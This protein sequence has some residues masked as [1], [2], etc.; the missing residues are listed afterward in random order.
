LV[1]AP[2]YNEGQG[3]STQV[4]VGVQE[5]L[6]HESWIACDALVSLDK[7]LLTYYV[8]SLSPEKVQELN[9]ALKSALA[10]AG[11]DFLIQ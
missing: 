9:Q 11:E 1:C 10:L 3:L 5:G 4:A 6:Q 7:S 2:V 8:G